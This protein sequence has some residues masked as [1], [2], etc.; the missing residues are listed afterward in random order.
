MFRRKR[1]LRKIV[2]RA[3]QEKFVEFSQEK[4]AR[5]SLGTRNPLG[6][7]YLGELHVG[8]ASYKSDTQC[9]LATKELPAANNAPNPKLARKTD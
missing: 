3:R 8:S 4:K 6:A 7:N 2:H 1:F 9:S 5:S